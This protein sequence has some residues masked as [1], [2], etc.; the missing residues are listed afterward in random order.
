MPLVQPV[1]FRPCAGPSIGT[2]AGKA[3]LEFEDSN[4][5]FKSPLSGNGRKK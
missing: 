5:A 4:C 2:A 1:E 3:P